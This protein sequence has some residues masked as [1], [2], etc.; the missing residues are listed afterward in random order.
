V[1]EKDVIIGKRCKL[2]HHVVLRAGTII[3]DDVVF[4]DGAM[5]T[6]QCSIGHNCNIRTGA[7]ISKGTYLENDV[8]VGPGVIT[9]HTKRVIGSKA[10]S[11]NLLTLVMRGAVLGSQSSII[12]GVTIG[13]SVVVGA[14]SVVTKDLL[15]E[16]TYV[17]NPA[18]R[19]K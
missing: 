11:E 19:I 1:V 9:N 18:R 10:D 7:I 8:F 3:G 4:A 14:G 2:G 15:E 13:E 17:G 5:T 6:G 16:G 12:A